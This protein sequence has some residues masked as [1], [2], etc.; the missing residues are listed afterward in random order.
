[1]AVT[2]NLVVVVAVLQ[3]KVTLTLAA[4]VAVRYSVRAVERLEEALNPTWTAA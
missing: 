1:M 3:V 2:Q 4:G